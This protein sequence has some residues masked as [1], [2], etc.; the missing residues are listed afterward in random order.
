MK[1]RSCSTKKRESPAENNRE[2]SHYVI[3]EHHVL[4]AMYK[5]AL[6][7]TLEVLSKALPYY[8]DTM[9]QSAESWKAVLPALGTV[10][11][12]E[13][14]QYVRAVIDAVRHSSAK[15]D[16]VRVEL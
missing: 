13:D 1:K 7:S 6:R 11:G 5:E 15:G 2:E 4:P 14:A 12:F 9:E 10:A 16:W 3:P 8:N